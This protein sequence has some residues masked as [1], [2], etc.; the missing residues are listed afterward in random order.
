MT[1]PDYQALQKIL[2]HVFQWEN[3]HLGICRKREFRISTHPLRDHSFSA[4]ANFP[5][6]LKFLTH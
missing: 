4:Y 6:K 1:V 3:V 2:T 5:E